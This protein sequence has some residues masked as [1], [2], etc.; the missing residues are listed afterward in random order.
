M[1]FATKKFAPGMSLE[2]GVLTIRHGGTVAITEAPNGDWHFVQGAKTWVI[3]ATDVDRIT[4]IEV[5][6]STLLDLSAAA[7]HN[8]NIKITGQGSLNISGLTLTEASPGS[9]GV[10]SSHEL[11]NVDFGS[12]QTTVNGTV[13]YYL[14][15]K[16]DILDN[17]YVDQGYYSS[18]NEAFVRLGLEYVSYLEAGGEP[19]NDFTAK[20][21]SSR[22]QLLHDNLLGNLNRGSIDSRNFP[23]DLKAELLALVPDEYETRPV[24]SGDFSTYGGATHDGARAF[25]YDKGWSRPDYVDHN[26]DGRVDP[27][28]S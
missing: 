26:P 4:R 3:S 17:Q 2:G 16:W 22:S 8:E 13:R 21:S 20:A 27:R 15:A 9:G 14:I 19:F 7:L 12:I 28:A 5:G 23:A 24:F 1:K 6:G 25:D 11:K 18:A 10:Q